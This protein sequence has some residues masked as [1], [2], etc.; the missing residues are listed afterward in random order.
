MAACGRQAIYAS[1][2]NRVGAVNLSLKDSVLKFNDP[3]MGIPD[4]AFHKASLG[5]TLS[6]SKCTINKNSALTS[7]AIDLGFSG[8]VA[9][10][11]GF[12]RSSLDVLVKIKLMKTLK[13]QL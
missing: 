2:Y 1:R 11:P 7:D 4:Q 6:G 13:E 10:K 3:D 8:K 12:S 5:A 9:L